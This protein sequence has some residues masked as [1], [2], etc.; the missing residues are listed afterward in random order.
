MPESHYTMTQNG[1]PALS[2]LDNILDAVSRLQEAS[3]IERRKIE[4]DLN[5]SVPRQ[6][7][8]RSFAATLSHWVLHLEEIL[9]QCSDLYSSQNTGE[10]NPLEASRYYQNDV[11]QIAVYPTQMVIHMP[12]LPPRTSRNSLVTE[13][14][15]SKLFH[16]DTLPRWP[17]CVADFYHVYPTDIPKMPKD[18]DNYAYKRTI[19]LLMYA[20][21]SSD[22]AKAFRDSRQTVF[23]DAYP[24]GTYIVIYPESSENFVF[25]KFEQA[26]GDAFY[27]ENQSK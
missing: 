3:T 6:L 10:V 9:F 13:A 17:R 4:N 16:M 14:L 5:T 18:V 23:T 12:H 11:I 25:E 22:C 8:S 27:G 2:A 1:N 24:Q 26:V 7:L 20:L 15:A 19:D 21:Q